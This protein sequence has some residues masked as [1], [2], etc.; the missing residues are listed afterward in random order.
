MI[1]ALYPEQSY[2]MVVVHQLYFSF[3]DENDALESSGEQGTDSSNWIAENDAKD[4]RSGKKVTFWTTSYSTLTVTSTSFITGTT[5]TVS[6]LCSL[7]NF[8]PHECLAG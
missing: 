6:I 5:V 7:P 1:V 2:H 3:S 8:F 4:S